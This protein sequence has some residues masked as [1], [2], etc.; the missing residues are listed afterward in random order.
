MQTFF[1]IDIGG[2][3]VKMGFVSEKGELLTKEKTPTLQLRESGKFIDQLFEKIAVQLDS[4]KDV[5]KVGI[6]VPGLITK[7]RKQLLELANIPEI[8]HFP[9][10]DELSKR[11]PNHSF[12]MD[13]DANA[14]AFG[15][16]HFGT[17]NLKSDFIFITLGTGIGS[18]AVIDGEIFAGGDGNGMELGH[19]LYK[20]GK[21]LENRIGKT[22][23]Q[24][25]I[26]KEIKR[27]NSSTTLLV[28]GKSSNK[29]VL[30]A[31]NQGDPIALKVYN[32]VGEILGFGVIAAI[33]ILDVKTIIIGGGV[34]DTFE[35]IQPSLHKMVNKY[36][37]PYYTEKIIL[38][39][40]TLGNEAG[41]IGAA[42]LCFLK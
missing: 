25:I 15:E 8:S 29:E 3:N 1:G 23:I 10:V 22:G 6:G 26:N 7:D 11:F 34:S 38:K 9:L 21:T 40:A 37:T 18:S 24:K 39:R 36:L 27:A 35:F 16:Y 4:R 12:I 41:I 28:R 31:A 20:K 14:A 33:R 13:N 17:D 30:V 32:K 42:S 5:V 19:M 2:T